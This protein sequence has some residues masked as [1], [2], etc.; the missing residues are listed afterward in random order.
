MLICVDSVLPSK[1]FK[2]HSNDKPWLSRELKTLIIKK[3]K[4]A[5]R[6][7]QREIKR[8]LVL[9]KHKYKLK[10]EASL[11]SRK[12]REAWQGVKKMTSIAHKGRGK[13]PLTLNGSEGT[14]MANKLNSFFCRFE[15]DTV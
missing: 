14:E 12:A 9:D 15:S 3:R 8:Q 1:S 13:P 6:E 2:V 4:H 5:R 7:L 10:L 11:T